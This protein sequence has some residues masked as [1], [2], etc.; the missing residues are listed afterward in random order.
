MAEHAKDVLLE[1]YK[2][3]IGYLTNHLNRMWTCFNF[4]VSTES[5]LIR[6]ELSQCVSW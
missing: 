1:D 6:G 3:R 2:Q 5:A 4:F